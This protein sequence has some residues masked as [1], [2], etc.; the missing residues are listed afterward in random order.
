MGPLRIVVDFMFG[1]SLF[2]N[3]LLFIPQAINLY[4]SKNADTLS[5]ITFIGFCFMQLS[6][7]LYGLLAHDFIL[8]SGYTLSFITCFTVTILIFKYSNIKKPNAE[9]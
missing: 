3:A 8:I 7:I 5:K 9:A 4:R 2:V 1:I 6:A